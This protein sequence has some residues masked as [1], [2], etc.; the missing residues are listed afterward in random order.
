MKLLV[1]LTFLALPLAAADLPAGPYVALFT[2]GELTE[3][4]N[5]ALTRSGHL[6][7]ITPE[8]GE[9][10][11]HGKIVTGPLG[12]RLLLARH[13][14]IDEGLEVDVVVADIGQDGFAT[15]YAHRSIN[16]EAR[17]RIAIVLRTR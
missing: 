12:Q 13:R 3:T 17:E 8:D 14:F 7:Q 2:A 9:P 10:V 1:A 5:V 16:G 11:M 15:G 6:V 4:R